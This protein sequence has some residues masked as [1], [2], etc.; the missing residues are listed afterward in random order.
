MA[1][2]Q[3]KIV[4]ES[5]NPVV[6]AIVTV[7]QN[8][9][10]VYES[11]TP[12]NGIRNATVIANRD[13][14]IYVRYQSYTPVE[15]VYSGGGGEGIISIEI[16]T[17]I[18]ILAPVKDYGSFLR[19][20]QV[21]YSVRNQVLDLSICSVPNQT[22][23]SPLCDRYIPPYELEEYQLPIKKGDEVRWIMQASEIDYENYLLLRIGIAKRGLIK[24]FDVGTITL[25]DDQVFCTATVPCLPDCEN[26]EFVI[27]RIDEP[28]A[29][30]LNITNPPD[31]FTCIGEV[32]VTATGGQPPYKYSIN[33]GVTWQTSNVFSDLCVGTYT[34][35]VEDS[36]FSQAS[37]TL[38]LQALTC[39]QFE[40]QTLQQVID[41][42]FTLGEIIN[43]ECILCDFIE[44]CII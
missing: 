16:N 35:L 41:S 40:G 34:F 37:T 6:G 20:S 1:T 5:H 2:Q 14:L 3:F 38:L 22:T 30:V 8:G 28:I 43:A 25:E 4:D 39:G 12:S 26:Y 10:V 18:N 15:Y 42:G 32:V 31:E 24:A 9:L 13:N 29:I 11:T 7:I 33:N 23:K 27:Y 17:C 36:D 21:A 44:D 19:W